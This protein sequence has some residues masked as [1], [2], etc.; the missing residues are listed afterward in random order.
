MRTAGQVQSASLVTQKTCFRERGNQLTFRRWYFIPSLSPYASLVHIVLKSEPGKFRMLNDYRVLNV[1]TQ[2]DRCPLPYLNNFVDALHE[3]AVF[4]KLHCLKGYYQ[5]P[6]AKNDIHK[7]AIT[8]P[9][10][11]YEYN[12]TPFG[13]RTAS[14]TYQR[15]IDQVTR[16]L[17]FCYA[18]MDDV[19]IAS[20]SIEEHEFHLRTSLDRFG[21]F[22][23]VLNS[24][25]GVIG[26]SKITFL[27]HFI[28]SE[29]LFPKR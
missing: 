5:I 4:T 24:R 12:M 19:L 17:D 6:M 13:L 3:C 26:A 14:N 9:I 7:T 1:S 20:H 28:D 2:P 27:G 8:T 25:K 16:G 23:I 18:Y 21:K 22:G 10:G 29:G 15:Y 11:L